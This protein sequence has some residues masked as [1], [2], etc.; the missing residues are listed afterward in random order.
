MSFFDVFL[1]LVVIANLS[2]VLRA[3]YKH[4]WRNSDCRRTAL[5]HVH[6]LAR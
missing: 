4:Y 6:K 3:L 5:D 2:V 1:T